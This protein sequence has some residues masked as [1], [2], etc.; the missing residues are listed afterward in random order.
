[1]IFGKIAHKCLQGVRIKGV[2]RYFAFETVAC[3]QPYGHGQSPR[4]SA[5]KER[6]NQRCWLLSQGGQAIDQCGFSG[7]QAAS[8]DDAECALQQEFFAGVRV[9][10]KRNRQHSGNSVTKLPC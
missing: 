4:A 10:G 9:M 2:Q 8:R 3:R 5:K 1:M 7:V 6:R